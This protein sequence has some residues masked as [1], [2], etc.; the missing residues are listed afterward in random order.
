MTDASD[1][2]PPAKRFRSGL[3]FA[4][5]VSLYQQIKLARFWL[6]LAIVG[7]VV[8][9]QFIVLTLE[10]SDWTFWANL[11]FYG[12]L[13]P[14]VTFITLTWIASEVR[15]REK[16][17]TELR[18]LFDELQS[19]HALLSKIQKVTEQF[20]SAPDL[21]ATLAAASRGV[22]EVTEAVG[23]G[24]FL[25]AAGASISQSHGLSEALQE[26]AAERDA[27]LQRSEALPG[28]LSVGGRRYWV[29]SSPLVWA[30]QLEGSLH[31]FYAR[32]PES[33]QRESFSILASE[34]SA[35]AEAA[36]S[37]TRDLLTLVEVDRSIRAEG[38]LERLLSTLLSQ[39]MSRAEA[40]LGGVYL[41]DEAHMLQ[42]AVTQGLPRGRS[43]QALRIG[44]GFIGEVAQQAEPRIA[45]SL[46]RNER[47]ASGGLLQT[48][49][50]AVALPLQVEEGLLGV[51]ALSHEAPGHFKEAVLPFLN[52]LAGQVSLAVRNARAYLQSEE[53]AI[54][55]ER[56]RIAREIHDGVA[57]SLAFSALKLDLVTRLLETDPEKAQREL[58]ETKTT[59]REMIKE[60][61]RSIFALRPIELEHHGFVETI[62]RY[63]HDYGQQNNIRVELVL[64]TMPQLS[65][66]SEAVLFRIFQE[67]M[68]NVAKHAAASEVRVELGT[69]PG[70]Q[71]FVSVCDDGRGFD[72][73][74]VGDRVTSAGGL[75]LRQM[76]ERVESRGGVFELSSQLGR[77]TTVYA[78]VPE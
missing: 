26:G 29:Q 62:R 44:E 67:A 13:G 30:G 48:A 19:S 15:Q 34:L 28:E 52:L 36:R 6:P 63:C 25:R 8:L 32:P 40:S 17:Q 68:H 72:P 49:G 20:A 57:Q 27:A 24:I 12:L 76:R 78:S 31:A 22:T 65:T 70:V 71:S 11:L 5:Q 47:E 3:P 23:V 54:A 41:A 53:L 45:A 74:V 58:A 75:G 69:A 42:L 10:R 55:E 64:G 39:M 46:S 77:G 14:A 16:A 35:A 59:L 51:V 38:N 56:A 43:R 2:S 7:V 21:E 73:Q 33:E 18:Q 1:S 50:S 9:H 61:R 60:V 4:R 66:K 37:R